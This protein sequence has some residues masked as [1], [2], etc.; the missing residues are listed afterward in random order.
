MR[1]SGRPSPM[2]VPNSSQRRARRGYVLARVLLFVPAL[3]L[4]AFTLWQR[5]ETPAAPAMFD[6]PSL[7][8]RTGEVASIA[9][10]E[11][12][13][14]REGAA[15]LRLRLEPLHPEAGRQAF[16]AQALSA[17]L[18]PTLGPTLLPTEGT[19]FT[20]ADSPGPWRL[21]LSVAARPGSAA[22]APAVIESLS[23]VRV[24]GLE[25][26][27]PPKQAALDA[28]PSDEPVDP[29][30]VLM[31][32]PEV[33]L[34]GGE[35]C[36]LIFWG[37]RPEGPVRAVVPGMGDV[38]LLSKARAAGR[39]TVSIARLDARSK[40]PETEAEAEGEGR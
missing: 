19:D 40:G 23:G 33:P 18:G 38:Q 14:A 1:E 39:S 6:E 36:D 35:S 11:G 2:T 31:A 28:G 20:S 24:D 10:W 25:P 15:P 12:L 4:L 26:L 7:P 16:D 32:T 8:M 13:V 21:T 29:L 5:A 9:G 17:A 22:A 27:V 3:G 30:E 34:R 37:P